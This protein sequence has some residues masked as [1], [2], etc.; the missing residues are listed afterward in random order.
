MRRARL[1]GRHIER[2]PLDLDRDAIHRDR[3]RG[4]SLRQIARGHR[5]STATIRH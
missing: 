3:R 2:N 1:E 5:V 4:P